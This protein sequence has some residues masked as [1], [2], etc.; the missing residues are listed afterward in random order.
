[1]HEATSSW[2]SPFQV[3]GANG[4][5]WAEAEA[6]VR[7][8]LVGRPA[9]RT[10]TRAR[11]YQRAIS[12]SR[13]FMKHVTVF[14]GL[15]LADLPNWRAGRDDGAGRPAGQAVITIVRASTHSTGMESGL[16]S[17]PSY[18]ASWG[19][20]SDPA[21]QIIAV[22]VRRSVGRTVKKSY[23]AAAGGGAQK[24][25]VIRG[26]VKSPVRL[27]DTQQRR[28]TVLIKFGLAPWEREREREEREREREREDGCMA[29]KRELGDV[30][31]W[32]AGRMKKKAGSSRE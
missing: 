3:R 22:A 29:K 19:S 30:T 5:T 25:G 15:H 4:S 16:L 2:T 7:R 28:R 27:I 23:P 13:F 10:G 31:D 18:V 21:R 8:W 12:R 6:D 9:D 11:L 14:W 24:T 32:S 1:M 17:Q 26:N 20:F